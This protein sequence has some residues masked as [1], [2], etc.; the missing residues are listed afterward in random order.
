MWCRL[1]AKAAVILHLHELGSSSPQPEG[2]G[3]PLIPFCRGG[4][5]VGQGKPFA[6]GHQAHARQLAL[7]S[8]LVVPELPP[9][10]SDLLKV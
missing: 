6:Q 8:G 1:R 7:S 3:S 10:H 9:Y 2:E 4:D 5:W